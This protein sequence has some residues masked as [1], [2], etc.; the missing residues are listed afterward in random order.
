[1][2]GAPIGQAEPPPLG[3]LG[4]IQLLC[5][6]GGTPH[7]AMWMYERGFDPQEVLDTFARI[8]GL[9]PPLSAAPFPDL[10]RD[11]S[12]WPAD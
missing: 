7:L 2:T 12:T 9:M 8:R 4:H 11:P 5:S 10:L 6:L 1:M 3:R